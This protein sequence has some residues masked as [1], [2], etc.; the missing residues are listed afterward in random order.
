MVSS[1]FVPGGV[2]QT[3]GFGF[4]V[5]DADEVACV[6]QGFIRVEVL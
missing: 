1:A 5:N 4:P 2:D 3:T 6:I